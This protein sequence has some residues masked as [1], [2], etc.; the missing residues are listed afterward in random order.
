M[1]LETKRLILR[2]WRD[3][4][5]PSLFKFAKDGRIGYAAGWLP[6]RDEAYSRAVIRTILAGK[7]T[8]AICLKSYDNNPVGSIGLTLEG[9][10]ERPLRAGEAE[11]GFWVGVPFWGRGI[12]PEAVMEI[13]R[14]GFE[15]LGLERIYCGYFEGNEKSRR[16][17][18]K[19]GFTYHHTNQNTRL[20]MLG[21]TRVEHVNVMTFNSWMGDKI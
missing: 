7:E 1:V 18:Q 13:M 5:A 9:S 2:G 21:E 19:C 12:A 10:R 17:Q 3:E 6:H 4:D 15:D 16:V 8:Y 14:H 20:I 11:L